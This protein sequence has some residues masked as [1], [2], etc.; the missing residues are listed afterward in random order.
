[1]DKYYGLVIPTTILKKS[2]LWHKKFYKMG[3]KS[4]FCFYFKV[5]SMES[6]QVRFLINF[7]FWQRPGFANFH[8]QLKKGVDKVN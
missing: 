7:P 1:M 5:T 8:Y 4:F 6:T 2:K 3:P